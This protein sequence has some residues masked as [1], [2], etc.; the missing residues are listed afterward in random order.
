[1]PVSPTSN[2][3]DSVMYDVRQKRVYRR[4]G[5]LAA[6][7][8]GSALLLGGANI[9]WMERHTGS[10]PPALPWQLLASGRRVSS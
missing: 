4:L 9:T 3:E 5:P 7:L 8:L 1:M 6:L 2:Q 10:V